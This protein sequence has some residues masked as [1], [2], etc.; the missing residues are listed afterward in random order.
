MTITKVAG[1]TVRSTE[2][3]YRKVVEAGLFRGTEVEMT[4][5]EDDKPR[6]VKIKIGE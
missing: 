2:Q 4:I 5:E 6:D 1:E 3:F